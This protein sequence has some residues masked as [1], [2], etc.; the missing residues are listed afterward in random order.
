MVGRC[1]VNLAGNM[2]GKTR[3]FGAGLP[4]FYMHLSGIHGK[5]LVA[6][7]AFQQV[8]IEII[9]CNVVE[10]VPARSIL[11]WPILRHLC[12]AFVTCHASFNPVHKAPVVLISRWKV[13][14]EFCFGVLKSAMHIA[15]RARLLTH[16]VNVDKGFSERCIHGRV[17]YI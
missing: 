15:M 10:K 5:L 1:T 17:I 8:G 7:V 3:R 12:G 13:E 6:L 9:K 14:R 11:R 4:L 2:A 16:F